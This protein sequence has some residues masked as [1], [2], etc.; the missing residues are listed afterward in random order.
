MLPSKGFKFCLL[1]TSGSQLYVS[2]DIYCFGLFSRVSSPF[3][4]L[5]SPGTVLALA[6]RHSW[7]AFWLPLGLCRCLTHSFPPICSQHIAHPPLLAALRRSTKMHCVAYYTCAAYTTG[8]TYIT[9]HKH[10]SGFLHC[11]AAFSFQASAAVFTC[12]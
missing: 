5:R 8:V 12:D 3:W 2:V 10:F 6:R 4:E 9:L 1:P 11:V 7:P